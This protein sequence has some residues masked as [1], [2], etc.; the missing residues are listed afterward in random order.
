MNRLTFLNLL[1]N[2]PGVIV[3]KYGAEWCRPCKQIESYLQEKKKELA[4]DMEYY[5]LDVDEDYDL[6][7]LLKFQ[8]QVHGIPVLLAYKKG[9]VT[10]IP[11][12]SVT[13]A[14]K[15]KIDDFFGGLKH[16]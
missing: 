5:S 14:D 4:E 7:A 11:D 1:E 15:K 8:K 2:N 3:V 16:L 6:Y 12:K 13:G 10:P 9:N